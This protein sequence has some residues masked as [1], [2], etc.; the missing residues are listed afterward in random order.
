MRLVNPHFRENSNIL[1][2]QWQSDTLLTKTSRS[3]LE[4]RTHN[5]TNNRHIHV[6]NPDLKTKML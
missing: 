5:L 1:L 3:L 2:N 6:N 4:N